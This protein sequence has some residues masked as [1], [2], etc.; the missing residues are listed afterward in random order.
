MRVGELLHPQTSIENPLR[1]RLPGLLRWILKILHDPKYHI[2]WE[3]QYYSI[4]RSC[5]IFS[6]NSSVTPRLSEGNQRKDPSSRC[7]DAC[8]NSGD[9]FLSSLLNARELSV[10]KCS[11]ADY[12]QS[13]S[14]AAGKMYHATKGPRPREAK[15]SKF[16]IREGIWG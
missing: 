4:L 13:S 8:T 2:P 11:L 5:R 10:N 12:A 6:I 7:G 1:L 3:L 14:E 15:T 16:G 9:L